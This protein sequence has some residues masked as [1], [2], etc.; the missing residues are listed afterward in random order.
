[1]RIYVVV[2]GDYEWSQNAFVSD[3]FDSAVI[4]VSE[5]LNSKEVKCG[6]DFNCMECWE[7]GKLIYSYGAWRGDACNC[8]SLSPSEVKEDIDNHIKNVKY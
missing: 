2:R 8:K 3:N 4:F 5:L 6:E 7:D 1:M